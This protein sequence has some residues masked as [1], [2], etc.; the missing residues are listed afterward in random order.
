ML[1]VAVFP[2]AVHWSGAVLAQC[3][4]TIQT[5]P[6]RLCKPPMIEFAAVGD[7]TKKTIYNSLQKQLVFFF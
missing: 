1:L 3:F 4:V 5:P 2:M 7:F 6:W